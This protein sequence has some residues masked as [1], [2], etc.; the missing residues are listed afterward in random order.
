MPQ[1]PRTWTNTLAYSALLGIGTGLV[2]WALKGQW[3]NMIHIITI[4]VCVLPAAAHA[5][6][7]TRQ[8]ATH[9]EQRNAAAT[10]ALLVGGLALWS[11]RWANPDNALALEAAGLAVTTTGLYLLTWTLQRAKQKAR[12]S[13]EDPKT[14]QRQLDVRLMH[15]G[16]RNLSAAISILVLAGCVATLMFNT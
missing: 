7:W 12:A 15:H 9:E 14:A 1:T 3:P 2:W 10:Q 16:A 11:W 4:A 13:S 6:H 8:T 5:W